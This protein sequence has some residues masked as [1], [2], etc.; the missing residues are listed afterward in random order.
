MHKLFHIS[1]LI[2]V[3]C[4]KAWRHGFPLSCHYLH[5]HSCLSK[6]TLLVLL[7]L[8]GLSTLALQFAP[9]LT[10]MWLRPLVLAFN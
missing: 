6:Y 2:V 9:L 10:V 3:M 5:V 4:A 7:F 8:S 1:I